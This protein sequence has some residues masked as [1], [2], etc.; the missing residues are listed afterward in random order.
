MKE[1]G[2]LAALDI[3]RKIGATTYGTASAGKHVFL[4]QRGL[5]PAIDYRSGDWLA[6]LQQLTGGRGVE[7]VIDPIGGSHWKKSYKALRATG[8]LGMFG[9]SAA[10]APGLRGKLRLVK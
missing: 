1:E 6:A 10:A 3:A 9:F 5:D 2:G 7:L 8:R 4:K